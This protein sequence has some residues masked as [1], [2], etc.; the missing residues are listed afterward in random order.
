MLDTSVEVTDVYLS[1]IKECLDG[2]NVGVIGAWGIR[3]ADLHHFHDEV[4][5]GDADAM[6]A[7]CF[8]FRRDLLARV[9]LMRECFRFYRNL[10]LDYSFQFRNLG[11][12]IIADGS[13]PLIRHEHRQW[14][15]LG[16]D[17]RGQLS[18]KNFKH[19]FKRW[20]HRHDLL[21]STK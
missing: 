19:F 11:Y 1:H 12:R 13:I 6:Q 10:D 21:V 8:A 7:Y 3:S 14:S 18:K 5:S 2:P 16:D 17:E 4:Q 9:G 15:A 20:G